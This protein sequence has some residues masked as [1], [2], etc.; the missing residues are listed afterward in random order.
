MPTI[1]HHLRLK[2]ACMLC[3]VLH[4]DK[5]ALCH[6]CQ[7]LLVPLGPACRQ[8]ATPLLDIPEIMLCGACI[9]AAPPLD[10]I[11]APFRFE[12]AARSLL[13]AYK[14]KQQLHLAH[15][16]ANELLSVSPKALPQSTV[17]IPVPLHRT[18]LCLR[19][20]NQAALLAKLL[21]KHYN[22]AYSHQL[23]RKVKSTPAQSALKFDERRHNL[24]NAFTVKAY[25][26][27]NI[28]LVDDLITTGHTANE[29]AA[30][31]KQKG[32]RTV[33]LWCVAKTCLI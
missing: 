9:K 19:G 27:Q 31:L 13:H 33:S 12:G 2:T 6:L 16:F 30:L 15:T 4:P 26:Y 25:T 23:I 14:F 1:S 21:A 24:K 10:E 8:C 7:L 29:I 17:F 32:A 22:A 20:F 11:Q 28:I 3:G 5:H 18:K